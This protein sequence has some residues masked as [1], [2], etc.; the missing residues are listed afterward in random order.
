[1]SASIEVRPSVRAALHAMID[2]AGLFPPAE[3]SMDEAVSEYMALR[4]GSAA[5]MVDRFI[6]PVSRVSELLEA[7]TDELPFALSVIVDV[8]L[9]HR[10]WFDSLQSKLQEVAALRT[11]ERR[12]G[13]D[14]LEVPLPA[15]ATMRETFDA[16]LGQLGASLERAGL[17]GVP[18]YAEMARGPRWRDLLPDTMAAVSR[19]RL[20]AKLRCGGATAAAFPTV[21]EVAAF[22]HAA[23]EAGVAFKATAGLH[24]P[25]RRRDAASGVVMHGFVNVLA[26]AAL[27]QRVDLATL[28]EVIAE[29][30]ASAFAFEDGALAWRD[31]R[32][33][34]AELERTRARRFVSYGS[35]SVEEPV[36]DL[37]E[38]GLLPASP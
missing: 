27:A 12:A 22:V 3:L 35:C 4:R 20:S 13:V 11:G 1:M 8:D 9:D 33:D 34:L 30:D 16:A 14:A 24:H 31:H 2:Y 28:E 18:V 25:I 15:L 26:A 17:R 5:W 37:V 7:C 6:V 10:R 23:S 38:L 21:P 36:G 19:A 32:A 29:E